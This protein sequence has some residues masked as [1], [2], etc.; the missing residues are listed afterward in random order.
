M[1]AA[2]CGAVQLADRRI[3]L[4]GVEICMIP[5]FGRSQCARRV[6]AAEGLLL[7]FIVIAVV[8]IGSRTAL[9]YWVDL[10]WFQS[11]GYSDV[12]WRARGLQ[13]GHLCGLCSGGR[14]PFYMARFLASSGL[15][16]E[17]CPAI[18]RSSLRDGR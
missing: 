7:F 8:V 10:L 1:S 13:W 18:I 16:P 4:A 17:S 15:T 6:V 9:S 2:H 12:F 5:L 11:V 14:L 3:G